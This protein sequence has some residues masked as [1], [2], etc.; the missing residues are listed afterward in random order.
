[1]DSPELFEIRKHLAK[2]Q[3]IGPI[4]CNEDHALPEWWEKISEDKPVIFISPGSS[5]DEKATLEILK[6][7]SRMNVTVL[8]A[9][10]GRISAQ[11]ISYENVFAAKY[12]PGLAA[13]KKSDLII[14]NGGSGMVYLGLSQSTP[15]LCIPTLMDQFLVSNA[16]V[17]KGAGLMIRPSRVISTNINKVVQSLLMNVTYKNKASQM[18]KA[19]KGFNPIEMIKD[20]I[21]DQLNSK[22]KIGSL[23]KRLNQIS[24]DSNNKISGE[25]KKVDITIATDIKDL[26]EAYQL[27]YKQYLEKGYTLKDQSERKISFWDTLPDT[28]TVVAKINNKVVGTLSFIKDSTAKLPMDDLAEDGLNQLRND[29]RILCELSSLAIDGSICEKNTVMKLFQFG[30]KMSMNYLNVSDFVITVNPRHRFFYKKILCFDAIG[31]TRSYKK[32]E[33]APAVPMRLNLLTLQNVYYKKYHQFSGNKNL[34]DFFFEKEQHLLDRMISYGMAIKDNKNNSKILF[35]YFKKEATFLK[36]PFYYNRFNQ[37]WESK[38]IIGA[39]LNNTDVRK[40]G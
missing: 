10:A 15:L 9:T 17:K 36:D 29:G 22:R 13:A 24:L 35:E 40:V 32:V 27:V 1:M 26:N 18:S 39:N 34:H 16:I 6:S 11:D 31:E 19:I 23:T 5:G 12:L 8:L 4:H 38:V 21:S 33:N 30:L 28:C 14:C 37:M 25:D 3:F 2:H 7:L 20:L